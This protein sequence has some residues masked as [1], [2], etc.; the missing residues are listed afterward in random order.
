MLK[1]EKRAKRQGFSFIIGI[2]EAG[3]GPLAGPVVASAVALNNSNFSQ[4]IRDSKKLSAFQ[5]ELAFDEIFTNA[6]VGIGI[7]NESIIDSQNILEATYFAM[8]SAVIH[9]ISKLPKSLTTPKKFS[10]KVC[11]LIDG[12]RFKTDLP[13]QY[14]T[15]IQGDNMSLSIACASIVAKV[16]RDRILMAYDRIFP[17]YG[18]GKHKGYPTQEHRQAI[19]KYGLSSI[20]RKSFHFS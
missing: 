1:H 2:D 15:I 3:R 17:E 12:N 7:M 5:R 10:E 19:R 4:E 13:Y 9:L 18:F 6:Y 16:A 8:N 11:L 14:K 20:H